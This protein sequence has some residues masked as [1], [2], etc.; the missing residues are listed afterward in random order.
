MLYENVHMLAGSILNSWEQALVSRVGLGLLQ[1]E[2]TTPSSWKCLLKFLV[3]VRKT[4][5]P[6]F[7]TE[8]GANKS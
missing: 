4:G 2:L 1:R 6:R 5:I 7:F 8:Q 3:K